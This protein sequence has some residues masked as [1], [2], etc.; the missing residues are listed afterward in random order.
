MFRKAV[1]ADGSCCGC[2]CPCA[3]TGSVKHAAPRRMQRARP[4]RTGMMQDTAAPLA[5]GV[6]R[7][8]ATRCDADW[9]CQ[10]PETAREGDW[11]LCFRLGEKL[12]VPR[13]LPSLFASMMFALL[14]GSSACGS[15]DQSTGS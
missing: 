14:A 11:G 2:G 3:T 12:M 6:V 5:P 8:G 1:A 9:R 4:V 13:R 15:T 10:N 7:L